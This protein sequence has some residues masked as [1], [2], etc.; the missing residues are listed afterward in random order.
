MVG[1]EGEFCERPVVEQQV[2][3]LS[4]RELA[5]GV[6]ALDPLGSAHLLVLAPLL[7]ELLGV[8]AKV[9][10]FVDVGGSSIV[11]DR[12]WGGGFGV[13][14]RRARLLGHRLTSLGALRRKLQPPD[15]YP[16]PLVPNCTPE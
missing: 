16:G 11:R 13:R 12:G 2:Q 3:S 6:L 5:L 10:S 14:R 7:P 8:P 1:Q 9:W 15:A 4:Y